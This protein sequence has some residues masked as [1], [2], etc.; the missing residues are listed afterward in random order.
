M[1]SRMCRAIHQRAI[2]VQ[3]AY[4]DLCR[5]LCRDRLGLRPRVNRKAW[6]RL[7]VEMLRAGQ[8]PLHC[9][10]R[11][12][13]LFEC[14]DVYFHFYRLSQWM[15]RP[16]AYWVG[17]LMNRCVITKKS[18]QRATSCFP[19]SEGQSESIYSSREPSNRTSPW[20]LFLRRSSS[21]PSTWIVPTL[22]PYRPQ[23]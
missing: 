4:R 2:H 23:L 16:S 6:R 22:N 15:S 19:E 1:P 20:P 3:R 5:D 17:A 21:L 12:L 10:G 18:I 11:T 9:L 14:R 7:Y 13:D 8:E